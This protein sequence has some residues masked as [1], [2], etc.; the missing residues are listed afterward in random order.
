MPQALLTDVSVCING[1]R[2]LNFVSDTALILASL[3][4]NLCVKTPKGLTL[5]SVL[6]SDFPNA[7]GI[8]NR[9]FGLHQWFAFF[10]FKR[11]CSNLR[12]NVC[13][14]SA[15]NFLK[16]LLTTDRVIILKVLLV[17][18]LMHCRANF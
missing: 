2:S 11:L 8:A 16:R 4:K 6:T 1:L 9:R 12:K 13:K 3:I 15:L 18:H 5:L 7:A 10:I 14:A 17:F